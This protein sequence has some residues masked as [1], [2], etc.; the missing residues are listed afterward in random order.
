MEEEMASEEALA[1]DLFP[2]TAH[3]E[4]VCLFTRSDGPSREGPG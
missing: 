2:R 1:V 3:V 4:T